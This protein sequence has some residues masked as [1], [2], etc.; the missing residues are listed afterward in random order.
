MR[1]FCKVGNK[2]GSLSD[3]V[4]LLVLPVVLIALLLGV[5]IGYREV[6]DSFDNIAQE[7]NSSGYIEASEGF[8]KQA[9]RFS[10]F[11]DALLVF[12]F[13]GLWI[14]IMVVSYILGN[15]P[16]FTFLYIIGAVGM[17]IASIAIFIA[18]NY[19]LADETLGAYLVDWPMTTFFFE[20]F[21]IYAI[22]VVVGVGISLYMKPGEQGVGI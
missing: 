7:V 2:K 19:F 15:N 14:G 22:L 4:T 8:E 12:M 6:S 13:F 20:Y 9:D 1:G 21:W 10:N 5:Y 16:I 18:M 3:V 17:V 11:W